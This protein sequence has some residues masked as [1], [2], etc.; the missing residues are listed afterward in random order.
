MY[1]LF[2]NFLV[3]LVENIENFLVGSFHLSCSGYS[4]FDLCKF[5][6]Y[7]YVALHVTSDLSCRNSPTQ[8]K[9]RYLIL[10]RVLREARQVR[11][12]QQFPAIRIL[13]CEGTS[14]KLIVRTSFLFLLASE[15]SFTKWE[16]QRC[17]RTMLKKYRLS[18]NHSNHSSL[19]AHKN[20]L[21]LLKKK[22]KDM[23]YL[24]RKNT[25]K[26]LREEKRNKNFE[27]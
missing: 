5:R 12:L 13:Y 11:E 2:I 3:F 9:L 4:F 22:E 21:F 16:G 14:L 6:V 1:E 10:V 27:D 17:K 26:Q 7:N 25:I 24:F 23:C 15:N 19:K 8:T 20:I 18:V